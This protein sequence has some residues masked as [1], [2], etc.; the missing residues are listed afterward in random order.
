MKVKD[1]KMSGVNQN[2]TL[3]LGVLPFEEGGKAETRAVVNQ[4]C[5]VLTVVNDNGKF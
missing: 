1:T 4:A 5:T 3:C 2:Y